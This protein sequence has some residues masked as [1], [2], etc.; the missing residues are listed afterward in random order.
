MTGQYRYRLTRQFRAHQHTNAQYSHHQFSETYRGL[1]EKLVRAGYGYTS[2]HEPNPH[3]LSDSTAYAEMFSEWGW[4]AENSHR[5]PIQAVTTTEVI[6]TIR[7]FPAHQVRGPEVHPSSGLSGELPHAHI[8][9]VDQIPI[10]D[11]T[12]TDQTNVNVVKDLSGHSVVIS[13]FEPRFKI[14]GIKVIREETGMGLA[15]AK[16]FIENLPDTI[17]TGLDSTQAASLVHRLNQ[18][19]VEAEIRVYE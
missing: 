4:N 10:L 8:G 1:E 12:E 3:E 6:Q 17:K 18:A 16:N 19:H 7:G 9:P 2:Y 14:A 15:A 11:S 5:R 13:S